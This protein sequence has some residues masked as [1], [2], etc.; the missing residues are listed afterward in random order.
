MD[1]KC[2]SGNRTCHDFT[3]LIE[4]P[5][6][7]TDTGFPYVSVGSEVHFVRSKVV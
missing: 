4:N 5:H 1:V 3:F 7:K 2:G 6:Q